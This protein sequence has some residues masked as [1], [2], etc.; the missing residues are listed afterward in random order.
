MINFYGL[1]LETILTEQGR[2]FN[3]TKML[4]QKK[5][6][7][8]KE[9]KQFFTDNKQ[10]AEV[11]RHGTPDL[12]IETTDCWIS[13]KFI[14]MFVAWSSYSGIMAILYNDRNFMSFHATAHYKP[15][16]VDGKTITYVVYSKSQNIYKIGITKNF[17]NRLRQFSNVDLTIVPILTIWGDFEEELHYTYD[18]K[19]VHHKRE[20][21]DINEQDLNDIR[22]KYAD[23]IM[24]DYTKDKK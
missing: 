7:S 24:R 23:N 18:Q 19:R 10:F 15:M 6:P 13:W 20:W 16:K 3:A 5:T 11:A 8:D 14:Y 12:G 17:R 2:Y 22:Q 21:F 9:A 4:A 1:K